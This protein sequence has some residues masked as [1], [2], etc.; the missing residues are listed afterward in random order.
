[1]KQRLLHLHARHR[2]HIDRL[3][4][5]LS[6]HS[7]EVLNRPAPDGGWSPIQNLHHLLRSEE[8]SLAYV[9]KKMGFESSFPPVDLGA[10]WRGW[11]LLLTMRTPLKFKAPAMIGGNP[12]SLPAYA[13]LADTRTQWAEVTQK[14]TDFL[15]K[16]PDTLANRLVYK[17]PRAGK[18]TWAAV[19]RFFGVHLARH[20]R[21]IERAMR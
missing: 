17:H 1:M 18:I 8:L 15:E 11:L 12:E 7:D 2:A 13:T 14:W 10:R 6:Q 5:D 3:L 21:Q 19:L 16:M 9:H 20:R 4:A